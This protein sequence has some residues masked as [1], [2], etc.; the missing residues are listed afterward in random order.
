LP[1]G[2]DIVCGAVSVREDDGP[3]WLDFYVPLGALARDDPR[4][5][6]FPFSD[7]YGIP[8]FAWR[9][10]ID[11]WLAAIGSRLYAD[12]PFRL[13]LIGW[14]VS[15]DV[16]SDQLTDGT[17]ERRDIGYLIPDGTGLTYRE[18]DR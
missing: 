1:S 17:P 4:I 13:G 6:G 7:D 11:S 10:P 2:V 16:Y 9:R 5:G 14:Q 12:V 15:G 3:D 18:A 8:T